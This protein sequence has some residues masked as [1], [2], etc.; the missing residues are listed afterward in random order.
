MTKMAKISKP[1]IAFRDWLRV[2]LIRVCRVHFLYLAAYAVVIIAFD[3]SHVLTP[4]VVMRRWIAAALLFITTVGI[5]YLAHNKN[6]DIPTLK[7]LIFI[8]IAADVAMA[9][10]NIYTQRGMASR[11][12]FLFAIPILVSAILLNRAAIIATAALSA[13]AYIIAAVTYFTLNFNE[14][15]KAELYGEVGFYCAM[16]FVFAG[17][18]SV[19]VRFGGSTNDS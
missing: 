4:D 16:F 11:A 15:Y 13:A 1:P 10:F 6:N 19:L 5:W 8:L 17:L 9:S 18:L 7:R 12:V 14:G 2:S 3:A